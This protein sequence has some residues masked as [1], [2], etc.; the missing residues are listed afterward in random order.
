MILEVTAENFD[1]VI[2]EHKFIVID[3]WSERCP[4]CRILG[5]II[6][7]LAEKHKDK[8]VFGKALM[9]DTDNQPIAARFNI[10]V[11]PTLL[12]FKNGELVDNFVGLMSKEMLEEKLGL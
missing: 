4:P 10:N 8:I 5:P 12:V 9:D 6:D 3:C 7:E 2:K 11:V 1:S